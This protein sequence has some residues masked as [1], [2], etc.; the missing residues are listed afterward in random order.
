[1]F[2]GRKR[3]EKKELTAEQIA[4]IDAKLQKIG[5]NNKILLEKRHS[6]EYSVETLN[7]TMKFS[8]LS[9]DYTT[10]WNY[11]REIL[12]Y[13]FEN[14]FKDDCEKRLQTINDELMFLL[15]ALKAS[16]KSYTLWFQRQ[17]AILKGLVF[18]HDLS[19]KEQSKILMMEL[20]LCTKMLSMDERNF[21]CWNYRLWVIETLLDELAKR[22]KINSPETSP[23]DIWLNYQ[24][25]VVEDETKY[26]FGLINKNFSNYSAWHFRAKLMPKF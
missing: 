22:V 18:E 1:M 9:P 14:D 11:R 13:L 16:P 23:E 6:K 25:K 7:Q 2:H 5:K 3:T 26:A 4:E 20:G 19:K 12:T 24:K 15:K 17:W 8:F 10:L 21:H